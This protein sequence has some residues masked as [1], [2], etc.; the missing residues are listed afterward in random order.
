MTAKPA[1]SLADVAHQAYADSGK[2]YG[3]ARF[4]YIAQA[5]KAAIAGWPRC[6]NCN[7]GKVTNPTI[8][9]DP[10]VLGCYSVDWRQIDCPACEGLGRVENG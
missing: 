10:S 7:N 3:L 4:D 8:A 6:A 5:V 9:Y 2:L 1:K